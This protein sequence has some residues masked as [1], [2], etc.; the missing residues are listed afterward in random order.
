MHS[1]DHSPSGPAPAAKPSCCG[2]HHT[3]EAA[4]PP[5]TTAKYFCPMCAGVESDRPGSCPKCGMALERNPAWRPA[6]EYTCPMHPEIRQD[7]PGNCPKCGMALEPAA[8]DSIGDEEGDGE[9]RDMTRR[10]Q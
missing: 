8:I 1:A 10:L 4:S 3:P 9:L 5:P 7:H 6:T 2:S